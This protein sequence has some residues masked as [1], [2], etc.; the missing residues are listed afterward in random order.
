MTAAGTW[1]PDMAAGG[2]VGRAALA[3]TEG[4]IGGGTMTLSVVRAGVDLTARGDVREPA[5]RLILQGARR[6]MCSDV[7]E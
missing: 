3:G 1:A 2:V 5:V 7:D 4:E 6:T